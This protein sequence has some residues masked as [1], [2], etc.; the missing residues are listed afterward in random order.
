MSKLMEDLEQRMDQDATGQNE[1]QKEGGGHNGR[2]EG[3][4]RRL[5]QIMGVGRNEG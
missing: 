3:Q 5:G 1:Q 2:V 4:N